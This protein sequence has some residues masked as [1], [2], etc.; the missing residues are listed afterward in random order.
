MP[1]KRK[2]GGRKKGKSRGRGKTV[3]CEACGASV[4]IDKAKKIYRRVSFIEPRLMR[5]L[6]KQGAY[7]PGSQTVKYFCVACA[8][9][10]GYYSPR[11][12]ED[13]K[14]PFKK[15]RYRDV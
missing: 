6:K 7:V 1:K 2:S 11:K 4:P 15:R 14:K 3:Q 5:E 13:R 10:R 9:H 8:V 12:Q